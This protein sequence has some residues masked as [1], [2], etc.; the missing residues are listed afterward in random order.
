[1]GEAVVESTSAKHEFFSQL[2]GA[3][4]VKQAIELLRSTLARQK[5]LL[6]Q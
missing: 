4:S 6:S 5:E 2:L 3:E 1:M